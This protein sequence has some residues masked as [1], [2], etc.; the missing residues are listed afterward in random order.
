MT[1]T[2]E[3]KSWK[4]GTLTYTTGGLVGLFAWLLW[5]DFAWAIKERAVSPIVQLMLRE[6]KSSD[7]ING[8][9][10][11][12]LPAAL[13]MF[14]GPIVSLKSD[15]HRGKLG[16]RIPFLLFPTPIAALALIALAFTPFFG[17]WLHETLGENSPGLN[18]SRVICFGVL[19]G[20]FEI[21]T[22][23]ANSVYNG[24][25]NDVVP[26]PLLGRFF[27]L[28]RAFS[29]AAGILF[30]F[31]L[32]KYAEAHYK[33]IFISIGV[34]YGAGFMLMCYKVKEGEYPPPDDKQEGLNFWSNA[35]E[36]IRECFSSPFYV[37]VFIACTVS[38]MAFMPFNLFSVFYAKSI[39]MSMAT[40]GKI[41]AMNFAISLCIA[42]LLGYLADRFHPLRVGMAVILFYG[43][44]TLWAGHYATTVP[45]FIVAMSCHNVISGM[46]FT[47]TA[48]LALRLFPQAKFAQYAAAMGI[49]MSVATMAT[50]PSVGKILDITGHNYR[51]TFILGSVLA[52]AGF[53]AVV[54]LHKKFMRLGGP[55]GY[56]PPEI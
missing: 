45:A 12:T 54:I 48:S 15:R 1:Q 11:G 56:V 24:L 18:Q 14:L 41:V 53:I 38:A 2:G 40:Y 47:G 16:R 8:L 9:L 20:I 46:W 35:K 50:G 7:F 33:W 42:Y 27:G 55:K 36:Y 23:I 17:S 19:W 26:Q 52:F 37:W 5:G 51:F 4:V 39:N 43:I 10:L 30:N 25:I 6:F 44:M 28:F 22:V 32:I 49:L 31:W 34:L 3:K 13:Y 29:L 21:A